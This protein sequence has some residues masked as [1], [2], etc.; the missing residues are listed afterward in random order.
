MGAS[1]Q[2]SIEQLVIDKSPVLR[3]LLSKRIGP[4]YQA[5]ISADDILQEVWSDL[6]SRLPT[7]R[8]DVPGDIDRII[9]TI[10]ERRLADAIKSAQRKKRGGPDAIAVRLLHSEA[11]MAEV[12]DILRTDDPTPSQDTATREAT[13]A[14]RLALAGVAAERRHVLELRYIQGRS[15]EEIAAALNKSDSSINSLLYHGLRDLKRRLGSSARFFSDSPSENT[16]E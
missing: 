15:R 7:L 14:V 6:N 2:V 10:A 16:D 8:I 4:R 9:F 5:A 13:E 12:L 1:E 3:A 11:D